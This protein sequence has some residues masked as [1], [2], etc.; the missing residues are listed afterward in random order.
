MLLAVLTT[1]IRDEIEYFHQIK[2]NIK[3]N[4]IFWVRDRNNFNKMLL[5]TNPVSKRDYQHFLKE[6]S[7]KKVSSTQH[8][9]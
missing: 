4:I 7:F 3:L 8:T 5:Y 9:K 2:V 6:I 1:F